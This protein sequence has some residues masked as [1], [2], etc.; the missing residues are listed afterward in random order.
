MRKQNEKMYYL[1]QKGEFSE[2]K[3]IKQTYKSKFC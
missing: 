1:L 3:V 2:R